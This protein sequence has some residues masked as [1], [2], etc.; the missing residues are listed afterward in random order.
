MGLFNKNLERQKFKALEKVISYSERGIFKRIDENR[1][2][3]ELLYRESP[4]LMEKCFWIRGWLE[5]QDVFLNELAEVSGAKNKHAEDFNCKP[6]PRP[7]PT[8]PDSYQNNSL[9]INEV[10][11]SEK[12]HLVKE[13]MN[14]NL[15]RQI[16]EAVQKEAR[17]HGW[18]FIRTKEEVILPFEVERALALVIPPA[19]LSNIRPFLKEDTDAYNRYVKDSMDD[20]FAYS[21]LNG[22]LE[23]LKIDGVRLIYDENL[24][25]EI[26]PLKKPSEDIAENLKEGN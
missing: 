21:W 19:W 8:T 16:L 24:K 18:V 12:Y 17:L 5:S 25:Q 9:R 11:I 4:D 2:L 6:F 26:N 1:E 22:I 15:Y 13:R 3:L 10:D 20:G 14:I 23:S 7:F